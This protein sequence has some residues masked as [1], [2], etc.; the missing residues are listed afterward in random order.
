[1]EER[2]VAA[3]EIVI[4]Q[5]DDGDNFY[6]IDRFFFIYYRFF[7]FRIVPKLF[8]TYNLV[9]IMIFISMAILALIRS[10]LM[11]AVVFSENWLSCTICLVL[12][13]SKLRLQEFC[14]VWLVS[15]RKNIFLTF[16]CIQLSLI[17]YFRIARPSVR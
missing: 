17:F 4:Q 13:L 7:V 8:L 12:L 1:M 6:V 10:A 11:M 2:H 5:G 16:F 9:E 3:A 14:G 15:S